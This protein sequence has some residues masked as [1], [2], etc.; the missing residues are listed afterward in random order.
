M[1]YQIFT[2]GDGWVPVRPYAS[3]DLFGE[4]FFVHRSEFV[5]QKKY[6]CSHV[7]TGAKVAEGLTIKEA[8]ILAIEKLVAAGEAEVKDLIKKRMLDI[9]ICLNSD[10]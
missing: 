10:Q 6:T 8:K 4:R 1:K 7:G 5:F 2:F 9:D 3:F